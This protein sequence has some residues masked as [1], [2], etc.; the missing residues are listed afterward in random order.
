MI[1]TIFLIPKNVNKYSNIIFIKIRYTSRPMYRL[2][3]ERVSINY[4]LG[5]GVKYRVTRYLVL[6]FFARDYGIFIGLF[7]N[8]IDIY[9]KCKK[10]R[11]TRKLIGVGSE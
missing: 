3:F 5:G 4:A 6:V 7:I 11:V 10:C 9:V 2:S 1:V 8:C